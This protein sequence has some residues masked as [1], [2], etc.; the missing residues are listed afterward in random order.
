MFFDGFGNSHSDFGTAAANHRTHPKWRGQVSISSNTVDLPVAAVSKAPIVL[1]A[2]SLGAFAVGTSEFM[3]GG[4][5]NQI[6]AD[7]EV[8]IPSAGLLITGYAIG[9]TLGGPAMTI[10]TGRLRRRPQLLLLLAIFIAGNLVCALSSSFLQ[11]LLGR[12]VTAF[13]HGAYIG[14]ASS[15]AGAMVQSQ[16]RARALAFVSAGVMIAN[17]LGVPSGNAIG[18]L[19]GWQTTFW[20]VTLLG[21][22]AALSL[23]MLLPHDAGSRRIS[24]VSEFRA[25]GHRQVVLGLLHSLCFTCGLFTCVPYLTPMLTEIGHAQAGEVPLFLAVFGGGATVGVLLGGRLADWRLTMSVAI[26]LLAQIVSYALLALSA[27]NL[28]LMWIIVFLFGV[29][30]MLAVA[31]LRMI[32]LAGAGE[33]PGLASTMSS[34]AFNL[35]VAIG[36]AVGAAMLALGMSYTALPLAGIGFVLL[37]LVVLRLLQH[38]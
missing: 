10:L 9:V 36:A 1:A 18:Q 14:S 12:I 2:L 30:A 19:L 5:L 3:V 13:C 26:A 15:A 27:A 17:I 6:A 20:A 25:L 22:A 29:A 32:V 31:P 23:A 16:H 21:A 34:S 11:L 7:L 35:G 4:L 37:G 33:A 38:R 8:P 28:P 24:A